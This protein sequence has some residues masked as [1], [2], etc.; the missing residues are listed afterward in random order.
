MPNMAKVIL[1]VP[2]EIDTEEKLKKAM[3]SLPYNYKIKFQTVDRWVFRK[4]DWTLERAI[5][6]MKGE[7]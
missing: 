6:N 1:L 4:S 5:L 7:K 2:D 3:V